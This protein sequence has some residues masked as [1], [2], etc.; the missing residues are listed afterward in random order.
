M[1]WWGKVIGGTFGFVM[2]GPLGAVLGAALG[3][4]FDNGMDRITADDALLGTAV[5]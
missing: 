5:P 1:S 4:Y 2:G 3:N